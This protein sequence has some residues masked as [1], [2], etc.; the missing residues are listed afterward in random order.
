MHRINQFLPYIYDFACTAL[1]LTPKLNNLQ[2][3]V[4]QLIIVSTTSDNS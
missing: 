4:I 1:N 2:I 3:Q